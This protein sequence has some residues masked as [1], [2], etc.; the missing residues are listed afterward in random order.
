M[1]EITRENLEEYLKGAAGRAPREFKAHLETCADC[2]S[3]VQLLEAQAEWLRSLRADPEIAPRAGFYGRVMERIED[4][5]RTSIWAVLLEPAIGRRLAWISA[6][7]V[8]ALGSYLVTAELAEPQVAQAP[9]T[10]AVSIP[11]QPAH[12]VDA[13]ATEASATDT[14]QQQQRRNAVLVNLASYRQ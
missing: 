10:I 5:R 8:V 2:A 12:A 9:S 6:L 3:E 1:H 11:S 14:P 13:S 7:A 4:Q